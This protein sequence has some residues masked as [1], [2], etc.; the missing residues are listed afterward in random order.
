M[1]ATVLR[2]E[3]HEFIDTI[4][5]QNLPEMKSYI[6]SLYDENYWKPVLEPASQEEISQIDES[7][8]EFRA[9]PASF[10]PWS[11]IRNEYPKK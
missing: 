2:K 11:V 8:E 7:L 3:L 10:R 9:N 4:P 5:D 6:T 1:I